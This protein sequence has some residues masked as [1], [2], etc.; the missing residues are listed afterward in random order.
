MGRLS[1]GDNNRR[2]AGYCDATSN[3]TDDVTPVETTGKGQLAWMSLLADVCRKSEARRTATIAARINK[4]NTRFDAPRAAA[5][6]RLCIAKWPM[7]KNNSY[8]RIIREGLVAY[9]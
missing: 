2:S 3:S 1:A 7:L 4:T 6:P 8:S 5:L 9:L